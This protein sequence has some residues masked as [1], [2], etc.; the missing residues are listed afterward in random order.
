[1]RRLLEGLLVVCLGVGARS[2][3]VLS[4]QQ[5]GVWAITGKTGGRDSAAE[6]LS[7]RGIHATLRKEKRYAG[8]QDPPGE[9]SIHAEGEGSDRPD[10]DPTQ[11]AEKASEDFQ[12]A[13]EAAA[14]DAAGENDDIELTGSNDTTTNETDP[15]T[16]HLGNAAADEAARDNQPPENNEEEDPADVPEIKDNKSK[17]K[18]SP[19]DNKDGFAAAS[20]VK[21]SAVTRKRAEMASQVAAS[22]TMANLD[23]EGNPSNASADG[24][25]EDNVTSAVTASENV[26][27]DSNVTSPGTSP[28][29]DPIDR[30]EGQ[31]EAGGPPVSSG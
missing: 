14:N 21:A 6:A 18:T 12:A 25:E 22:P 31:V 11:Q 2:L 8:A 4:E 20:S 24:S 1:M 29:Q 17:K 15:A 10:E 13:E 26:V 23:G 9:A 5:H 30:S 16:V 27:A 3:Q 28:A 19:K 7:R